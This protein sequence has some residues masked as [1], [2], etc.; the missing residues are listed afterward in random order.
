MSE[1]EEYD[2]FVSYDELTG[3][4]YA[5]TIHKAL[6]R[7][8]YKVFVA[9]LE[10]SHMDGEFRDIISNVIQN[11]KTFILLI[12]Y[13]TLTRS[14]VQREVRFA[15]ENGRLSD[16]SNFWIFREDKSD[17][18][19]GLDIFT[20]ET[21]VNLK[22]FNQNNF[23]VSGELASNTLRKCDKRKDS[24]NI[25]LSL[26]PLM[27][28]DTIDK[29]FVK[30]FA[31]P[32]K[33]QGYIAN[34]QPN[35]WKE[36]YVD[37]VLQK[38][39]EMILC[40]F[41]KSAKNVGQ[42]TFRQLLT[43]KSEIEN[44]EPKTTI[45]LW[46][47]V[48]DSFDVK[49]RNA[50]KNYGIKLFD[51]NTVEKDS[52]SVST[53]RT[54]YPLNSIIH[55]RIKPKLKIENSP[56]TIQFLIQN[57]E[58]IF[59]T[60][61]FVDMKKTFQEFDLSM[62]KL[63]LGV[64]QKYVVK[65]KQGSFEASNTF[66][67]KKRHSIIQLDQKRYTW[68]DQV[69]ITVISPDSDKDDQIAETIGNAD[70]SKIIIKTS[71]G[72]LFDYPL[73]ETGLSTGV[74][75]GVITLTGFQNNFLN[76]KPSNFGITSDGGP[77]DGLLSCSNEDVLE[78]IYKN[79]VETVRATAQIRWNM[80]E[81][82]W[83]QPSYSIGDWAVVRVIDPDMNLDPSVQD[84]FPI[85]IWSDSDP[86]GITVIVKETTQSSGIFQSRIH[87][88]S[89]EES[90]PQSLRV[91]NDD[92]ITAKYIDET[93]PDPYVIGK[94]LTILATAVVGNDMTNPLQRIKVKNPRIL[95]KD[96][97]QISS[98]PKGQNV[99]ITCDLENHSNRNQAFD[100]IVTIKD[101]NEITVVPPFELSVTIL[102]DHSDTFSLPW[103]PDRSGIY[104]IVVYIWKS[105]DNS[106]PLS[107]P[108][109][110]QFKVT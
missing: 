71:K 91:S 82:Q 21:G 52:L 48:K 103:I 60:Q 5:K 87:L 24:K 106:T 1:N 3:S 36:F 13:D 90:G 73:R 102:K 79:N 109:R 75:Q 43:F 72:T 37:L 35:N 22:S 9:H 85:H 46:V 81:V 110:F 47:I 44:I 31:A 58:I 68:S 88:N 97:H 83:L 96:K 12:N 57:Q 56:I 74:F 108:T 4:D 89:L 84:S 86:V 76:S 32:Y 33:E 107:P 94:T 26:S 80:G 19:R 104:D 11:S 42:H 20:S 23:T 29:K 78:I 69:I 59:E 27:T 7:R 8:G 50:A 14:E 64:D 65:V 18:L 45:K 67:I 77:Q 16:P 55:L 105:I 38:N 98:V 92:R 41:K 54:I 95:N 100:Y 66:S 34:L 30:S 51:E 99:Y 101:E 10:R 2:V 63:T 62:D 28:E 49:L 39:N 53:D 15:S 70:D 6:T 25:E 40:E 17:V 61:I 93:L